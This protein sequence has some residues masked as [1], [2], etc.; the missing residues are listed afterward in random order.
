MACI[1]GARPWA[2][3]R[4]CVIFHCYPAT[5]DPKNGSLA[6]DLPQSRVASHR[7]TEVPFLYSSSHQVGLCWFFGPLSV[8]VRNIL[9]YASSYTI[10]WNV[11]TGEGSGKENRWFLFLASS[12]TPPHNAR[13][14][15]RL[16]AQSSKNRCHPH[17]VFDAAPSSLLRNQCSIPS[18]LVRPRM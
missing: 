5:S 8:W 15:I 3:V 7:H 6:G 14:L 18:R 2:L 1:F 10:S 13:N 4:V 11:C 9:S 16:L 17:R 12:T